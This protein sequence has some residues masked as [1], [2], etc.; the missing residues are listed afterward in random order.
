MC[1]NSNIVTAFTCL[2]RRSHVPRCRYA[3]PRRHPSR[4]RPS[5]IAPH[6]SIRL[7]F[8]MCSLTCIVHCALATWEST[9]NVFT[10][11]RT[12]QPPL[13]REEARR[14]RPRLPVPT[15]I[16]MSYLYASRTYILVVGL[17]ETPPVNRGR[18]GS[19]DA[20]MVIN[21]RRADTRRSF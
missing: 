17:Y 2:P 10:F 7:W 11:T 20:L 15:G 9:P 4:R 14:R 13:P 1:T 12:S 16:P 19:E 21:W 8:G 6:Y 5:F 3:T 18:W